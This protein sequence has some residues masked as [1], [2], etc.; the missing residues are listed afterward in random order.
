[1]TNPMTHFLTRSIIALSLAVSIALSPVSAGSAQ[2]RDADNFV[3]ALVALGLIGLIIENSKGSHAHDAHI[4]R[5]KRL[6]AHCLKSYDTPGRD[7]TM[8]SKS[9][10]RSHFR[11]WSSLPSECLTRIRFRNDRGRMRTERVYRPYCLSEFGYV[12][13][14]R[15]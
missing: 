7:R 11:Y 1:M 2:A 9:C 13:V 10:F 3:A 5:S 14:D 4:P 6:P 15:H 8:F 12:V